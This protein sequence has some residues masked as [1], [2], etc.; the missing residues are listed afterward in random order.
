[1]FCSWDFNIDTEESVH[2]KQLGLVNE[3]KTALNTDRREIQ[4]REMK[5]I[6]RVL[7]NVKRFLAWVIV[8][9]VYTGFAFLIVKVY[10]Y[11][12]TTTKEDKCPG[13]D[14]I[15]TG[16]NK[17][18]AFTCNISP[19]LLTFT[20]TSM[21]L[22]LPFFFFFIIQYEHYDPK[23]RLIVDIGRS[24]FLR[25]MSL[26]VTIITLIIT[27]DC[28][29]MV[30]ESMQ[31]CSNMGITHSLAQCQKKMCWEKSVGIEFYKLTLLDMIIQVGMVILV[32]IPRT[33]VPCLS[34]VFPDIEFNIPKHV[35]DI[36]YSQTICW[37]GLF[38]APLLSLITFIKMFVIFYL[39]LAYLN[40]ICKPSP[41]LYEASKMSSIMKM[42]LLISFLCALCPLT[43]IIAMMEPSNA[44]GPFRN[45]DRDHLALPSFYSG[46]VESMIQKWVTEEGQNF[47]YF[48]G[49][50]DVMMLL[51]CMMSLATYLVYAVDTALRGYNSRIEQELKKV[52]EETRRLRAEIDLALGKDSEIHY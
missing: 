39:R 32:D 7:L 36:V 50:L 5:T 45:I 37:M 52:D 35:L 26:L 6:Q 9:G 25:L 27:N 49:R 31:A 48:F 40:F 15:W 11:V 20:I 51:T 18:D 17:V 21:N 47:L 28:Q 10:H 14:A 44:C 24:I 41:S 22:L 33:R 1:V 19:Y 8:L 30:V 43:Y 38:F 29:Y 23:T 42:F 3:M 46:V 2:I 16:D 13:Y 4:K 12:Q 34:R